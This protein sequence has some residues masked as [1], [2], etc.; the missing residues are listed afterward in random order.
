LYIHSEQAVPIAIIVN[1]LV[2]NSLKHAFPEGRP[3]V[4]QVSL[5]AADEVVVSVADNGVG[6]GGSQ[7][8]GIGSRITALLAQQLGG[9]IARDNLGSGSSVT[10]R[11]PRP[12]E[13]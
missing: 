13:S 3:G 7:E 12:R 4:I 8:E 9:T 10:L 5:R 11:M 6:V 2:T 1:E